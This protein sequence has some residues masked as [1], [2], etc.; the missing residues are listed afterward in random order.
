M[1]KVLA[2]LLILALLATG[3]YLLNA[4]KQKANTSS[5]EFTIETSSVERGDVAR[6][7]SASGSVR[8]LTTVEVG[9]QV[10]GQI[11]E[12]TADFNSEVSKDQIIARLDPQTFETRVASAEADVR[13]ARANIDVLKAQI[14]RA[15]ANLDLYEKDYKRQDEL[16]AQ[17]LI[18][19]SSLE[20]TERQLIV[21]RSDLNVSNAQLRTGDASLAQR[22]AALA[23]AKVDLERT[24]IRSPIDGVVIERNV[25]VGQT[26]AASLSAPILFRIAKNLDDIRIDADVVEADIGGVDTGDTV[27]FSVDAY[28]NDEFS[29]TV[30]QVRLAAQ[31][32]QNV[33]TYTVVIAAE[34]SRSRLLPG[35]T[36]NV[37]ITAEKRKDVLRIAEN[38]VRFKPGNEGPQLA[39]SNNAEAGN[40]RGQR[41]GRGRDVG[42]MLEGLE[43]ET[44]RKASIEKELG[45]DMREF[46]SSM[47]GNN[48]ATFDRNRMRAMMRTR[49]E[50]ILKKN[51]S[52]EEFEQYEKLQKAAAS[53]RRIE[54]YQ[55]EKDGTLSKKNIVIG[56]SD[57]KYVEIRRG[58]NEGD[59]FIARILKP[60]KEK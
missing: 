51:L 55:D 14:K 41:G 8:A 19:R 47:S 1:K 39:E 52:G 59:E 7:V 43:L 3:Y 22:Q 45:D 5:T 28:P 38:T 11:V 23:I 49:I 29:G 53:V 50:R 54:L 18:P 24:I 25:D 12:L 60:S 36:A 48:M 17:K 20:D 46:W 2:S 58:A 9:S 57:G 10:S 26:V 21:G 56:L 31:E 37:E 13:S 30:E 4:E 34:N 32:L 6:I 15:Q 42:R 40:A 27:T 16:F 44:E 35:M 33:V